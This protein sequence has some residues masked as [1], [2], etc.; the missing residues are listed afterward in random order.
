MCRDKIVRFVVHESYG[1]IFV[2]VVIVLHCY[3]V[4]VY[5]MIKG[6]ICLSPVLYV[7]VNIQSSDVKR[8]QTVHNYYWPA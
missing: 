7:F 2:S 5:N 3:L 1:I 4:A 6:F 8:C